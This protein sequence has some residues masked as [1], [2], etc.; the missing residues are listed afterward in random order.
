MIKKQK[1]HNIKTN[2]RLIKNLELNISDFDMG[3]NIKK[4]NGKI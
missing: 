4:E 1:L 3:I 2:R